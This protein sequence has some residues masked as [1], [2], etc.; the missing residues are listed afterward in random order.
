MVLGDTGLYVKDVL[1]IL[2]S[3][4]CFVHFLMFLLFYYIPCT[5]TTNTRKV[6][7]NTSFNTLD[8]IKELQ[9]RTIVWNRIKYVLIILLTIVILLHYVLIHIY[10]IILY[11]CYIIS[12]ITILIMTYVFFFHFL[13]SSYIFFNFSLIHI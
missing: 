9:Y 1:Y 6:M 7:N 10:Y 2:H 3:L 5:D 4:S 11:I 12:I 8:H 13:L